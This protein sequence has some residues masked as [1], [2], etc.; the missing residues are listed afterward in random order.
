MR[1]A[2]TTFGIVEPSRVRLIDVHRHS[3]QDRLRRGE[4]RASAE[5][6]LG[7]SGLTSVVVAGA[8]RGPPPAHHSPGNCTTRPS[9]TVAWQPPAVR[10]GAER[11]DES[12]SRGPQE[13]T[14]IGGRRAMVAPVR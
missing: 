10:C 1:H 8:S 13:R 4:D 3:R 12:E 2:K 7:L 5:P 11:A 9:R 14:T 6:L